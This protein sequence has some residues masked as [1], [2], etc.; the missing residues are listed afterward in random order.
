MS[1]LIGYLISVSK[2][3]HV[4]T[5]TQTGLNYSPV[6]SSCRRTRTNENYTKQRIEHGQKLNLRVGTYNRNGTVDWLK[7]IDDPIINNQREAPQKSIEPGAGVEVQTEQGRNSQWNSH[8]RW[9]HHLMLYQ[10]QRGQPRLLVHYINRL[11][12]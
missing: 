3:K 6:T 8:L 7:S 10:Q 11:I 4:L 12:R 5:Q 1:F 2:S 9:K